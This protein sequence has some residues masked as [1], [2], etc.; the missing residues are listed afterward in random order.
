MSCIGCIIKI[1]SEKQE[2]QCYQLGDPGHDYSYDC[3][4]IRPTYDLCV[5]EPCTH[6]KILSDDICIELSEIELELYG[7]S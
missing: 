6:C 4:V 2:Q 1:V 5:K 3:I 7:L